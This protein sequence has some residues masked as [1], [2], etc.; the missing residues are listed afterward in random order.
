MN[1]QNI[2][3]G[4]LSGVAIYFATT[5]L[6]GAEETQA[7]LGGADGGQT[8]AGETREPTNVYNVVVESSELPNLGGEIVKAPTKKESKSSGYTSTNRQTQSTTKSV[9]PFEKTSFSSPDRFATDGGN[10]YIDRATQQS[11]TKSE[12]DK[13]SKIYA[14]TDK[15]IFKAQTKKESKSTDKKKKDFFGDGF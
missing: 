1:T 6:A 8:F 10:A 15:P 2:V 13:R 7:F 12:A 4:V 11:V 14:G 3:L 5:G 9:N